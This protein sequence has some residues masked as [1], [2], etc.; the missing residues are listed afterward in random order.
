VSND[1]IKERN[2][3]IVYNNLVD[4]EERSEE[5]GSLAI[6]SPFLAF[7][8]DS[9][10]DIFPV[11]QV[12]IG[13]IPYSERRFEGTVNV[14]IDELRIRVANPSLILAYSLNP[15]SIREDRIKKAVMSA[16]YVSDGREQFRSE[17][18]EQGVAYLQESKRRVAETVNRIRSEKEVNPALRYNVLNNENY[19]HYDEKL[20]STVPNRIGQLEKKIVKIMRRGGIDNGETEAYVEIIMEALRRA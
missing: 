19:R 1:Y 17:F 20:S 2:M 18:V 12:G 10:I 15:L 6:P 9:E 3:D 5:F 4:K 16:I 13:P 7:G 8:Y 14:S 11:E